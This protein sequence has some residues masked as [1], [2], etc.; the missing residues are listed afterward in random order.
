M[1]I[2]NKLNRPQV[3]TQTLEPYAES[4]D[5]EIEARKAARLK[6]TTSSQ[7]QLNRIAKLPNVENDF[8]QNNFQL[9]L[10][11]FGNT[12]YIN[13]MVQCLFSIKSIIIFC[14][15]FEVIHQLVIPI[16]DRINGPQPMFDRWQTLTKVAWE[17]KN[18]QVLIKETIEFVNCVRS[19]FDY[20]RNTQQDATETYLFFINKMDE[21]VNSIL[22]YTLDKNEIAINDF[23]KNVNGLNKLSRVNVT[24]TFECENCGYTS[25]DETYI[26]ALVIS[27]NGK[28]GANSIEQ[29]IKEQNLLD[30]VEKVCP[31]C[32]KETYNNIKNVKVVD[33]KPHLERK[34][35]RRLPDY[36]VC[37]LSLF[38]LDVNRVFY[39]ISNL[40]R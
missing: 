2:I 28:N 19:T 35:I 32:S 8:A 5:I 40:K 12:C 25:I 20:N 9:G 39:K 36:I 29:Y 34:F 33:N 17:E 18:P 27:L 31:K 6:R 13:A 3:F 4:M 11:N 22:T 10:K 21:Y 23:A 38:E 30:R 1:F 7:H 16:V 24:R 14:Y 15:N 37:Y 26:N